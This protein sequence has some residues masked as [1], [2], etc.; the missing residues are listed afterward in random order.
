[1][2]RPKRVYPNQLHLFDKQHTRKVKMFSGVEM[3][4]LHLVKETSEYYISID[5]WAFCCSKFKL[6]KKSGELKTDIPVITDTETVKFLNDNAW[7]D[8]VDKETATTQVNIFSPDKEIVPHTPNSDM[9]ETLDLLNKLFPEKKKIY[10]YELKSLIAAFCHGTLVRY[11]ENGDIEKPYEH[12][13]KNRKYYNYKYHGKYRSDITYPDEINQLHE[14][15][16]IEIKKENNEVNDKARTKAYNEYRDAA[17]DFLFKNYDLT[18]TFINIGEN[19]IV[20]P[21]IFTKR[22]VEGSSYENAGDIFFVVTDD[23]VYFETERHF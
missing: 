3:T 9:L 23:S 14:K 20:C 7:H 5:S 10:F 18:Q 17:D 4:A 13:I 6:K 1:M 8:W 15:Y 19:S 2:A 12:D 16:L 11:D 21:Y 22:C